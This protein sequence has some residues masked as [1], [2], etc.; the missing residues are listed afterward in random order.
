MAMAAV[1]RMHALVETV[2]R[3]R[4][5]LGEWV[6]VFL[7]V[8]GIRFLLESFSDSGRSTL[9]ADVPTMVHY[10]LFYASLL[11][12]LMLVVRLFTGKSVVVVGKVCVAGFV[13]IWLAPVLDLLLSQGRGYGM[14][15]L[16]QEWPQ[17]GHSLFQYFGSWTYPGIT[18]GIRI[19]VGVIICFIA[20]Y[21]YLSTKMWWRAALAALWSYGT[22]FVWLALPSMLALVFGGG[23]QS[24][25]QWLRES[26]DASVLPLLHPASGQGTYGAL[27]V[28]FNQLIAQVCFVLLFVLAGVGAWYAKPEAWRA[29]LR[30]SRL[31][32]VVHYWLLLGV[33]AYAAA[34]D[35]VSNWATL[36]AGVV[37][38]LTFYA[39]WMFAVG[40][41][42]VEDVTADAVSN[43]DRPLVQRTLSVGEMRAVS[44][45][46]L[47][48][49]LVGG[50]ILG[51][52]ILF[53][54]LVFTAAYH[55]YSV[56]PLKLKRVPVLATFCIS[57][58]CLAAV[59]A[60][61]FFWNGDQYLIA[62]PFRYVVLIVVGFT[63]GAT[64]KDIKDID[65]DAK[66]GVRTLATLFGPVWGPRVIGLLVGVGHA[67]V[68]LLLAR[69]LLWYVALPCGLA[70][71]YFATR[72]PYQERYLFYVYFVSLFGYALLL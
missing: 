26:I 10:S 1:K 20:W 9:I 28:R 25:M 61:F 24:V 22:I 70:S 49:A 6:V 47:G 3:W 55:I 32:R 58:A 2:E 46:F 45:V 29:V 16:F 38:L 4:G 35:A 17:L 52:T 8:V 33:G 50:Y 67:L 62:F 68:P 31:E 13:I 56:P 57:L 60:G 72:T 63:L 43:S 39:A 59:L 64:L 14:A 21:V 23:A 27:Q 18:P 5:S 11:L 15:Y 51:Q 53:L 34:S 42:D 54:V 44:M 12:A 71:Y 40:V 41:N 36:F 30:N 69:P 66:A 7:G 65:G 48:L 37:L 19:E